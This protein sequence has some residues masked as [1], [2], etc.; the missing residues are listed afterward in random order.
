MKHQTGVNVVKNYADDEEKFQKNLQ[1]INTIFIDGEGEYK[2]EP[3][4]IDIEA[5]K[6]FIEQL[7]KDIYEAR[8]WSRYAKR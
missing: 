4:S 6:I 5:F 1:T 8:I 2:R 3:I 7:R